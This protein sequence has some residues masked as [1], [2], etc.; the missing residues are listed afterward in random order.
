MKHVPRKPSITINTDEKTCTQCGEKGIGSYSV[1]KHP[2]K[3]ICTEC[4][5]KNIKT[6]DK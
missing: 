2:G 6:I 1:P 5:L 3:Y 4:V